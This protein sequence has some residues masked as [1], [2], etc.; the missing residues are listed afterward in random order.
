MKQ[1][2]AHNINLELDNGYYNEFA[3]CKL[4]V[5]I[6]NNKHRLVIIF[7]HLFA[8]LLDFNSQ[9]N[10]TVSSGRLA[11]RLRI[12]CRVQRRTISFID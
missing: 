1:I 11:E 9:F 7:G 10:D 6:W 5:I 8:L 3:H 2:I 12:R 4:N